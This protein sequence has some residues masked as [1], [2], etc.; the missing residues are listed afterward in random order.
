MSK[1]KATAKANFEKT[2][3][4]EAVNLSLKLTTLLRTICRK[5]TVAGSIRQGK[6]EIGDVDIVVI[7]KNTETFY[8]DVKKMIEYEYGG[9]KKI[10][11]MF[12]GRPINIFVTTPDS[13]GACLYQSTGPAKYNIQMRGMAKRKGFKLNEYGLFD[14]DTNEMI[15]GNTENSIFRAMKMTY[16]DPSERGKPKKKDVN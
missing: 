4:K 8:E 10:F 12:D 3:R 1:T 11:G 9:A 13:F 6:D 15:A 2:P 7:P 14:R 5:V 16:K